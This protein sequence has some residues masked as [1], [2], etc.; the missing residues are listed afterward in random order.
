MLMPGAAWSVA[1]TDCLAAHVAARLP[2][3]KY[4]RLA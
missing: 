4:L 3:A 2:G 1:A